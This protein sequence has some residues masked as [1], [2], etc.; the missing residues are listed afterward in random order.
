MAHGGAAGN[1]GTGRSGDDCDGGGDGDGGGPEQS[2]RLP[3]FC[4]L[5][6]PRPPRLPTLCTFNHALQYL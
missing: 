4:F 1:G 3:P 2:S 6:D 5:I